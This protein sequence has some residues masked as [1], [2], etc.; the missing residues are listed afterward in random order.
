MHSVFRQGKRVLKRLLPVALRRQLR[1]IE[2]RVI[3]GSQANRFAL[4]DAQFDR[5]RLSIAVQMQMTRASIA[6]ET[7]LLQAL[8]RIHA[9]STAAAFA[10]QSH[11]TRSLLF[12]LIQGHHLENESATRSTG[13][14]VVESAQDGRGYLDALRRKLHGPVTAAEII[15]ACKV[16][17]AQIPARESSRIAGVTS[18]GFVRARRAARTDYR[19]DSGRQELSLLGSE[20][21]PCGS[22]SSRLQR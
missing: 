2:S 14:E 19:A 11:Q 4:L 22:I 10:E 7:E 20:A 9:E 17:C 12:D 1:A 6:H 5:T 16:V 15:G 13:R 18:A 3:H 8:V 21:E